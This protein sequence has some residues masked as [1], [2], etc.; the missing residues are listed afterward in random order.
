MPINVAA[1]ALPNRSSEVT[2]DVVA[3]LG[4]IPDR[5]ERKMTVGQQRHGRRKKKMTGRGGGVKTWQKLYKASGLRAYAVLK[6][7]NPKSATT[8]AVANLL[9]KAPADSVSPEDMYNQYRAGLL[10][11]DID[12]VF[13]KLLTNHGKTFQS[14]SESSLAHV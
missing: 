8:Q 9:S 14:F 10:G 13:K 4:F 2:A 12:Q 6:Q 5:V 11:D 3:R 7:L 1:Y